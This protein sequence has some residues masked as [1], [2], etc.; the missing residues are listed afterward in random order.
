MEPEFW[1][2]RW[3]NNEIGFHQEQYNPRL[4]EFWPTLVPNAT[5]P[6]FVPL[7][8]KSTDMVWL[9]DRGHTVY[10]VDISPIAIAG[11]FQGCNL[12]PQITPQ[13]ELIRYTAQRYTLWCGDFFVLERASLPGVAAIYDRASLVALPPA[14]RVRYAK[15]LA[16]LTAVDTPLLLISLDY[17]AHE[18]QGPPFG[19]SA[20]EIHALYG[21]MFDLRELMA[22]DTLDDSPRFRQRGLTRLDERVYALRRNSREAESR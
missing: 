17:P 22:R 13:G 12:V 10:G 5:A 8:G 9:H 14:L 20:Q 2:E 4:L 11:F 6:V 19:I 16:Q 18:M 3:K 21:P 7:C 1:I 15:H